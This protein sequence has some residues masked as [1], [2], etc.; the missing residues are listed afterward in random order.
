VLGIIVPVVATYGFMLLIPLSIALAIL[1]YNL[2]EADVL[3]N[4]A[5]VYGSLTLSL[6]ALY[7]G[8]VVGLQALSR[9]FVGQSSDLAIALATLVVAALFNPWRRRLQV[10]IDRRFYRHKYDASRILSN[11]SARLRDEVDL[12]HLAGDLATVVNDTV[13]PVSVALWLR[14]REESA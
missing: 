10:F 3:I 9:A 13:Q 8:G 14:H 5:L 4:R 12:D 2:W 6:A 7:I 11:F 1:R